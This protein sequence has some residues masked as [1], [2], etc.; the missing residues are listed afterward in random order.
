MPAAPVLM[1]RE[2]LAA[3]EP[4]GHGRR[5]WASAVMS[6]SGC[7][8][9]ATGEQGLADQRALADRLAGAADTQRDHVLALSTGLIGTY[10]P[11]ERIA[12]ALEEALAA[13]LPAG[14]AGLE[15]LAE[16]LRTTDSRAK[17]ASV[18]VSL[19]GAGGPPVHVTVS[20]VAKGVGMIHPAMATMLCVVLT[21][22][23]ATPKTLEGILRPIVVRTWDQLSVDGDQSTNDTVLLLAS[24][25]S[26][27]APLEPGSDAAV[28]FAAAV[29]AVA[30]S[31]ARQQAADGEGA[32][33]LITC[34]VSGGRDDVEARAVARA[35]V[36]SNLVKAAVHGADPNWGRIS[37]AAGNA[38]MASAEVLEAAGLQAEAARRRA[39]SPV[40]LDPALLRIDI[41][42]VPVY[43]GAPVAYVADEISARMRG[44]EVRIRIDLGEGDGTGEAFGCDLTE[45]YV[46]ENS[47]YST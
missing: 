32:T 8:N 35:V 28:R 17:A 30:R 47:A 3:T 12:T 40:E 45:A 38:V 26:G 22:A 41:E 37:M 42:G 10:L 43:A 2:H 15:A 18:V 25:A 39:G 20:G 23:S 36:R 16:A 19:P 27:A 6:T 7:A 14:D 9:A 33:S 21:D 1:D 4:D 24:G 44:G 29:E 5:G 13:G 34:Q 46:V 11:V 31:L